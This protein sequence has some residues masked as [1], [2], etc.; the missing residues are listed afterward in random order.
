MTAESL[1]HPI[2]GKQ[3]YVDFQPSAEAKKTPS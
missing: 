2:K 3:N 1:H